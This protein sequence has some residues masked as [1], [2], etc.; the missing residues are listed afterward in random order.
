MADRMVG[1]TNVCLQR[2]DTR[3]SGRVRTLGGRKSDL[4]TNA[5]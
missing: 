1:H 3:G 5:G 2:V 4:A